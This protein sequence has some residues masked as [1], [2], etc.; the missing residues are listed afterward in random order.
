MCKGVGESV[1]SETRI[2]FVSVID[3]RKRLPDVVAHDITG[4]LFFDWPGRR[5]AA[6]GHCCGMA[7]DVR[8]IFTTASRIILARRLYYKATR[9]RVSSAFL[10]PGWPTRAWRR[11][12]ISFGINR[13]NGPLHVASMLRGVSG[14]E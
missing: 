5:E 7:L 6:R 3:I 14:I 1:A 2:E 12:S 8:L 10:S 11:R 4:C 9:P 13:I